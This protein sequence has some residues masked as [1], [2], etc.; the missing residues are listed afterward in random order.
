VGWDALA[1]GDRVELDGEDLEVL[2]TP[3]HS[4][5]HLALWHQP[6]ATAFVGDLVLEGGSVMIHSSGGGDMGQYLASLE[7]LQVLRPKVMLPAHGREIADP[8]AVLASHLDHRRMRER[9]VLDALEV[10]CAS[11]SDI[12]K[13]IYHGLDSALWPAALENVRAHLEKLR[14]EGR[15]SGKD[16]RWGV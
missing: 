3:G 15:V 2:H 10:G 1:D 8:P 7:R 4:S 13:Y 6:S 11:P 14:S 5:D 9:Q 12:A 16:D